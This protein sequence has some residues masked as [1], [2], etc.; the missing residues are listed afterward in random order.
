MRQP[1]KLIVK[2]GPLR[3]NG[4]RLISVQYCHNQFR[5][6]I[7]GTGVAIPPK[8]WNKKTGRISND[9]PSEF[10]NVENLENLLTAKLRKAEDMVRTAKKKN[11]CPIQFLKLNFPLANQWQ[12]EHMKEKKAD[13]DVYHNI[14]LYIQERESEVKQ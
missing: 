12:I 13:L 5:R 6:V 10:G 2:K 1:I 4:T 7:V 8:Y 14:D 11:T 3:E 9:L